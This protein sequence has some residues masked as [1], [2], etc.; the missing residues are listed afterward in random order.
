MNRNRLEIELEKIAKLRVELDEVKRMLAVNKLFS[1]RTT[2]PRLDVIGPG[3]CHDAYCSC[4]LCS[5]QRIADIGKR[6]AELEL[7]KGE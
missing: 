4:N 3:S 1:K 6:I 2:D 5:L 7:T